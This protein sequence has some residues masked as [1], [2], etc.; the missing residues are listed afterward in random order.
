M[1]RGILNRERLL[2]FIDDFTEL[3]VSKVTI[4]KVMPLTSGFV[5]SLTTKSPESEELLE[6]SFTTGFL[7]SRGWNRPFTQWQ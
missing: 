2:K 6:A 5:I 1:Y 3:E 7:Y 4:I